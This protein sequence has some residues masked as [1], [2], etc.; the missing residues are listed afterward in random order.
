VNCAP[1]DQ[2]TP[3]RSSSVTTRPSALVDQLDASQGSTWSVTWL[4]R[5]SRACVSRLM[6]CVGKPWFTYRLNVA[7]SPRIVAVIARSC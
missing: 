3:G 6:R 7:G 2:V 5:T 4:M 1:S